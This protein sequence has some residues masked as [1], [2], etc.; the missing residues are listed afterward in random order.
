M[1]QCRRGW[2]NFKPTLRQRIVF[3]GRGACVQSQLKVWFDWHV[4]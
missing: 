2:A 4:R 1:A 3:A